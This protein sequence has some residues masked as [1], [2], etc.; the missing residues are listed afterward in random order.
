V[1]CE[2]EIDVS[3]LPYLLRV[4]TAQADTTSRVVHGS[5]ESLRRITT[6]FWTGR[7]NLRRM[8]VGEHI[9]NKWKRFSESGSPTSFAYPIALSQFSDRRASCATV[10]A[11]RPVRGRPSNQQADPHYS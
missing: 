7:I 8:V 1:K 2:E 4:F 9:F 10:S 5:V 11:T 6:P 3:A